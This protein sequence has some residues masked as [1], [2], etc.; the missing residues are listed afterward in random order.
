MSFRVIVVGA[1]GHAAVVADA[2][3]ACGQAVI[4]FT[5][6]DADRHGRRLCDLEVLGSDDEILA[7]HSPQ[8][9]RLANGI[10]G[11]RGLALRARVQRGLEAQGWQFVT[12]QHP[13]AVVSQFSRLGQGVQLLARSVVQP[14]AVVGDGSIINT[15]AVVEHDCV[16]GDYVH[17]A[18]GALLCGTVKVGA[19]C[20]IG[21]GA[22]V[23]QSV[24][25]G[26]ETIVGAGAVVIT[27]FE[28]GGTL[29]GAPAR[30]VGA[31]R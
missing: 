3:L 23:R 27:D 22:V 10:G 20:H 16:I 18:P 7:R 31:S 25:L 29:V 28:G 14:G 15:G 24:G 11:T 4:G 30:K 12:V 1:G 9:L 21:A 17:V 2:L 19:R 5:D 26:P 6:N 13:S 8:R